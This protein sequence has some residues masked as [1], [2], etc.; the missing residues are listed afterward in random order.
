MRTAPLRPFTLLLLSS[1]L[2][3][4]SDPLIVDPTEST[5]A[6]ASTDEEGSTSNGSDA[7]AS[8]TVTPGSSTGSSTGAADEGTTTTAPADASTGD[9]PGPRTVFVTEGVFFANLGGV[10]GADARCSAEAEAAGSTGEFLAW[11]SDGAR[12]PADRFDREGGPWVLADGT[13]IADD[14]DDLTDGTLDH[15]IDLDAAGQPL[16]D[17]LAVWTNTAWDGSGLSAD[18]Q[19]WT[20]MAFEDGGIFGDF[21]ASGEFGEWTQWGNPTPFPCEN[22][23]HLYCF[24][25]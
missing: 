13:P 23:F 14:W 4:F 5:A 16:D 9:P 21:M 2:G 22:T 7:G 1:P 17:Q 11:I 3:C 20:S 24:E 15:A 10:A 6:T 19:A 25:Q 8:G 18:C 12:S